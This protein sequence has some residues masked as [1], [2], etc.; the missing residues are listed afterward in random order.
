MARKTQYQTKQMA[1]LKSYLQSLPVGSHVTVNDI[2]AYFKDQGVTIGT[3]TVY[4]H[5]ERMVAEGLVAK[6]TVDGTT[7]A[8][9]E[10]LGNQEQCHKPACVHCKCEK[11]GKLIHLHCHEMVSL[12]EHVLE[13]HG[14]EMNPVRTVLYGICEECRK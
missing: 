11:C 7:S 6:Y 4:R 14:F 9:F 13:H 10:Y 12:E 8:C 3:T 1:E 5:L 2:C